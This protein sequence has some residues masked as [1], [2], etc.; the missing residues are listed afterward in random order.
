MQKCF[1]FRAYQNQ[2]QETTNAGATCG[3]TRTRYGLRGKGVN[4][5][6]NLFFIQ[7][8]TPMAFFKEVKTVYLH[9]K[10]SVN[11]MD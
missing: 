11:F 2:I 4:L 8:V 3:K 6:Q 9:H 1:A 10:L 5:V 7:C